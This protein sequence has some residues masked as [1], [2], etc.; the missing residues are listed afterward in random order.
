M[1][2]EPDNLSLLSVELETI[3]SHPRC[4]F[5]YTLRHS[6]LQFFCAFIIATAIYLSVIG[7]LMKSQLVFQN[8]SFKVSRV[9]RKQQ[10]SKNRSLWDTHSRVKKFRFCPTAAYIEGS[11]TQAIFEPFQCETI[12]TICAFQ[13]FLT[14]YC[15]QLSQRQLMGLTV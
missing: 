15:D 3:G 12:K 10:W 9:K 5:I 6:Y 4:D 1:R 7:I 14:K 11:V 13:P 8:Y 2:R